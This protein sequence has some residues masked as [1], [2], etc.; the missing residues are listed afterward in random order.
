MKNKPVMPDVFAEPTRSVPWLTT[1]SKPV[2]WTPPTWPRAPH[3]RTGRFTAPADQE[4]LEL[5]DLP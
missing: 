2:A 1:T 4:T 5:F 3:K